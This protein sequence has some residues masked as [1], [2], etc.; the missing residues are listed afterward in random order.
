VHACRTLPCITGVCH[1]EEVIMIR[2][3]LTLAV[4]LAALGTRQSAVGEQFGS[5]LDKAGV[6]SAAKTS[7]TS[8]GSPRARA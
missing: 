3:K 2:G 4:V 8:E 6:N 1:Q 5:A 7:I